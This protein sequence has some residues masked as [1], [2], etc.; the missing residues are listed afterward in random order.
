MLLAV[1]ALL[2]IC[3]SS[4][5]KDDKKNNTLSTDPTLIRY[6]IHPIDEG[7][8]DVRYNN[9]QGTF[10][11]EDTTG[12]FSDGSHQFSITSK[13]FPALVGLSFED[14]AFSIDEY[15]VSIYVNGTLKARDTIVN[16]GASSIGQGYVEY[17]VE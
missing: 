14:N 7:I 11:I 6:T 12:V 3:F 9:Q 15:E 8:I 1:S 2:I 17:T 16:S 5:K 13:P 4:C 10:T